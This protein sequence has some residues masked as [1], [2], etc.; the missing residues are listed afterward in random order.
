MGDAAGEVWRNPAV[1]L[2]V[3]VGLL[4]LAVWLFRFNGWLL[5]AGSTRRRVLALLVISLPILYLL[6]WW[7]IPVF[8]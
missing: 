2:P 5:D 4:V 1:W 6:G 7:V 3:K 8:V